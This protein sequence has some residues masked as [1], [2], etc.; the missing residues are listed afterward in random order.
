VPAAVDSGSTAMGLS[1]AKSEK[2]RAKKLL[3]LDLDKVNARVLRKRQQVGASGLAELL[4]QLLAGIFKYSNG[5]SS[6]SNMDAM[7]TAA[8]MSS[9]ELIL[10]VGCLQ[11]Q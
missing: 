1:T 7:T 8:V 9:A 6:G 4:L 5:C 10:S 2:K 3:K 11:Q